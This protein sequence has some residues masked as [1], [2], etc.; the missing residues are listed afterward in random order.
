MEM[1]LSVQIFDVFGEKIQS[2]NQIDMFTASESDLDRQL[3]VADA[4]MGGCGFHLAYGRKY[5]DFDNPN[6]FKVDCILFAFDSECIAELNKYAEKKFH[7]LNDQYRKYICLLY[8]SDA[9]D[10]L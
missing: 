2:D 5:I 6:A 1:K 8:T 9:A 3:R 4:K 7:E 10:E